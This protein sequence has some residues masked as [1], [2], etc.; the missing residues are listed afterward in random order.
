MENLKA[1]IADYL[2]T[3]RKMTLATVSPEGKPMGHTVEYVSD[4]IDIFFATKKDTRKVKNINH[5]PHVAYTVDEDYDNWMAIQGVQMA[6]TARIIDDQQE[7]GKIFTNYLKKFPFVADFPP[8]PDLVFVK[9]TPQD[10]YFLDYKKGFAHRD[11]V[12]F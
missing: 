6:G 5:N 7:A 2:G 11:R 9:V 8:N 4:G 1:Q 10:A 12:T 3:H